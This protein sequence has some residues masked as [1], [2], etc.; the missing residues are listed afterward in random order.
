MFASSQNMTSYGGSP[1]YLTNNFPN[2]YSQTNALL[3]T[4]YHNMNQTEVPQ[5]KFSNRQGNL[6]L[7]LIQNLDL[8]YI[9]KSNNIIPLEKIS[10]HLIFSKIKDEDYEDQNTPKLLKTFQYV[11][12]YLNEKQTKLV[13]TNEKLNVEY[14]QLINQS[15][16]IEEKLKINKNIITKNSVEKKEKEMIL[17]TYE[18]IV[19]FNCNPTDNI[20]VITKTINKNYNR[21]SEKSMGGTYQEGKFYCHICNGKFFN[22]ESKLE[23]HMKRRHLA[24][25]KKNARKERERKRD[26]EILEEY[27]KKLEETKNYLQTKIEQKN[28]MFSKEKF[29]DELNMMKKENE[30]KMNLLIDYTKNFPEQ[31]KNIFQTYMNQQEEQNNK[32]LMFLANTVSNSERGKN[33]TQKIIIENPSSNNINALTN[34][35]ENLAEIIKQQK[36]KENDFTQNQNKILKD[37]LHILENQSKILNDGQNRESPYQYEYMDNKKNIIINNDTKNINNNQNN[38]NLT[39]LPTTYLN[40]NQFEQNNNINST[41]KESINNQIVLNSISNKEDTIK[42]EISF[43]RKKM[44]ESDDENQSK[45]DNNNIQSNNFQTNNNNYYSNQNQNN[46]Q[47]SNSAENFNNKNNLVNIYKEVSPKKDNNNFNNTAP[48]S[49]KIRKF[50]PIQPKNNLLVSST[51]KE[52]DRFYANFMNREQPIIEE[53][54]PETKAYLEEIIPENKRKDEKQKNEKCVEDKIKKQYFMNLDDF[55][56]K[57]KNELFDIIGKTMENINEINSNDKVKQLYYETAQKAID[58]KLLEEDVKMMKTAY[59]KKGELKRSRS[60]SR[61]KFVIQQAEN[62]KYD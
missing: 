2:D 23:S 18:S 51:I 24:Q 39:N 27:D 11:L 50:R 3:H 52:L 41:Q 48:N 14:N 10:N 22:T 32:N 30:Q 45:N 12:E 54:K 13:N 20:N 17:I 15:Y 28:E 5:M 53:N 58:L 37:R 4:K 8:N 47:L 1:G 56:K 61:A 44:V 38:V 9:I 43:Q 7:K 31:M 6:N 62:E 60:S 49:L 46:Y 59:D 42:N 34:S 33:E 16:E 35:I 25:I 57:G 36:D 21:T 19:N 29:E 55:D 40:P 26:E